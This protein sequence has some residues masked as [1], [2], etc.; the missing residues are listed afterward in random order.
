MLKT[1]L[2]SGT[3]DVDFT[4]NP[5]YFSE[6]KFI[7]I[8]NK[9]D[10]AVYASADSSCTPGAD[11]TAEIASGSSGMLTM[12]KSGVLWCSGSGEIEIRSG[13]TAACPFELGGGGGGTSGDINEL[14]A[15]QVNALLALL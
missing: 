4:A 11:G 1:V 13:D 5:Y 14:T 2:L 9:S 8:N 15:A 7:W 6:D 12:P 10:S 3:A